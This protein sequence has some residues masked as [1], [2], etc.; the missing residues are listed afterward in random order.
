MLEIGEPLHAFDYD[1]LLKRAKAAGQDH[2]TIITRPASKG[3]T[4]LTLDGVE[5]ILD[6]FT[7]MVCDQSGALALAGV[8]GGAES[9]ISETT[10]NVL[11]EGAAWNMIN[12]RRTAVSQNL[13]SE[14]SY[15][16]SRGVH[17]DLASKGVLRGLN[18]MQAWT[19][20][21]VAQG[22]VDAYPLP[23][24]NHAV[25]IT[26]S[27][28]N[29]WLGIDLSPSQI[30]EILESLEFSS[31]IEGEVVTAT[32]PNHR[33]DIGTGVIGKSDLM[34]EI[35]RVYGYDKIP[36]TRMS[37]ELPP[38]T[39]NHK[40]DIEERLR[41]TLV[42]LGLQ[43]VITHRMT[44]V[45]KE[46]R[47]LS[48]DTPPTDKPYFSLTNP[49]S[50]ERSVLRQSLLASVLEVIERNARIRERIAIFEIS[51][52]FLR[53]EDG[54]LP[55]EE[56]RLVIA[57]TGPRA[58]T[59]WGGADTTPMDF[60][61]LKGII[62]GLLKGLHISDATYQPTTHPSFHPGKCARVMVG[63]NQIGVI[64]E[65]HPQVVG[66]YDLPKTALFG[67]DFDIDKIISNVPA[68]FDVSSIPS[69]PPI[70]EDIA[71]IV[72]EDIPA[73]QVEALIRQTGGR[74]VT[75]VRL[76]DVYRGE[77]IGPGK[78]SLA[79]NLTYQNPDRTLTDKDAANLR[80]KIV[81][82]LE[83]ELGSKLRG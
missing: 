34:E 66:N 64:G 29:R 52:I 39:G 57:L 75:D 11:L 20:G 80:N 81:R 12:T 5:R 67:A 37:D 61:D 38:Q 71:L 10:T 83:R 32:S 18:L 22:L 45:E 43:E 17:P 23:P 62:E 7:V 73:D 14:A 70:L 31:Q 16:F 78:K 68:L 15:R 50:I 13:S 47:R 60:F 6:D 27:D 36:L 9:E 21:I 48:P 24:E 51:S 72:D 65:L 4:L 79:Y 46:A 8:M 82:R 44:S 77:Q 25:S 49:I 63:Q 76:F 1:I 28:V 40:L 2:P 33:I 53:S 41:D 69:Q 19:G 74:T 35:A 30:A 26:P 42:N 59:D 3:E 54:D 58:L 55:E 56:K